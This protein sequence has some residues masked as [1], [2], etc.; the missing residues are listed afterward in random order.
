MD[1]W[2]K[3]YNSLLNHGYSKAQ[4]TALIGRC[5]RLALAT[6]INNVL[7]MGEEDILNGTADNE[8]TGD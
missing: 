6:V 4:A 3:V 5:Y 1:D 2:T 7:T 8:E